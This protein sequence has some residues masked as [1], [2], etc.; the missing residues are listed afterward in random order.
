M[1][2]IVSKKLMFHERVLVGNLIQ[3]DVT[4]V[5]DDDEYGFDPEDNLFKY[6]VCDV[7]NTYQ[8]QFIED[9]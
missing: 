2:K 1:E 4:P 9:A 6:P 7:C 8:E 3:P 5:Y